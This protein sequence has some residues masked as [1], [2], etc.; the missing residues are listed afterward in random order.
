MCTLFETMWG[1]PKHLTI[2][3]GT[4]KI[5]LS[6]LKI[7][8]ILIYFCVVATIEVKEV[9]FGFLVF[10]VFLIQHKS[11]H[12]DLWFS[13][14]KTET[15]DILEHVQTKKQKWRRMRIKELMNVLRISVL[16]IMNQ[17][18]KIHKKSRNFHKQGDRKLF[19]VFSFQ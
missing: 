15:L 11:L 18:K 3:I 4:I 9:F 12:V 14:N 17:Q 6:V 13:I 2:I 7:K 19:Y 16:S 8:I 1:W 10:T 5:S